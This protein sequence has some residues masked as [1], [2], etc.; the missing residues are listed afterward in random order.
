MRNSKNNVRRAYTE[1][2]PH[3]ELGLTLEEIN[4]MGIV[5]NHLDS[6]SELY[7]TQLKAMKRLG[8]INNRYAMNNKEIINRLKFHDGGDGVTYEFWIDP[9]TEKVYK[10]QIEIVRDFSSLTEEL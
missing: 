3:D 4:H 2:F 10:I 5:L 1:T 6:D 9:K 7:N 8:D